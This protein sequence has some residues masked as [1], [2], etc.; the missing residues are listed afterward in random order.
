[1]ADVGLGVN[2]G[3]VEVDCR[4]SGVAVSCCM[5]VGCSVGVR[6]FVG[7]V[8]MDCYVGCPVG[9]LV[10]ASVLMWN[11]LNLKNF[12]YFYLNL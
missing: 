10:W 9:S 4:M 2:C 1:M 12:S 8:G 11:N 6:Y 7:D 5:G 3:A